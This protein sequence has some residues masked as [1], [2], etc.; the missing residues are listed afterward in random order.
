MPDAPPIDSTDPPAPVEQQPTT[1]AT[2]L[3]SC[4]VSGSVV[5]DVQFVAGNGNTTYHAAAL[6]NVSGS[7]NDDDAAASC[8][9][10]WATFEF[11]P[12]LTEALIRV[13]NTPTPTSDDGDEDSDD[14][15]SNNTTASTTRMVI[16]RTGNSTNE[17]DDDPTTGTELVVTPVG[18]GTV[19]LVVTV[20]DPARLTVSR[21]T[22]TFVVPAIAASVA[23]SG[24]YRARIRLWA[25]RA[26]VVRNVRLL[27]Y[28]DRE[29]SVRPFPVRS[30]SSACV[31]DAT[32]V[33][34][35]CA[36]SELLP[37]LPESTASRRQQ[38]L[39]VSSNATTSD[40][41]WD[42]E[43]FAPSAPGYFTGRIVAWVHVRSS[44][45]PAFHLAVELTPD[46]ATRIALPTPATS[47]AGANRTASGDASGGSLGGGLVLAPPTAAPGP[48]P[49]RGPVGVAPNG[50][51]APTPTT[52][53]PPALGQA[54]VRGIFGYTSS[55]DGT[56]I[57]FLAATLLAFAILL[58]LRLVVTFVLRRR[59]AAEADRHV[60]TNVPAL[61]ALLRVHLYAGAAVPCHHYCGPAHTVQLLAHAL[62]LYAIAAAFVNAYPE[63]ASDAKGTVALGAL[64][65]LVAAIGQPVVAL[66]FTLYR[67]VDT[68]REPLPQSAP[69]APHDLERMTARRP[70][71]VGVGVSTL[72]ALDAVAYD[73]GIDGHLG[74]VQ[75]IEAP[76]GEGTAIDEWAFDPIA[77]YGD[78]GG[79]GARPSS[80]NA[81]AAVDM[82]PYS[83]T[84][85]PK[86]PLSSDSQGPTEEDGD[87]EQTPVAHGI[88]TSS[89]DDHHSV[90]TVIESSTQDTGTA[91]VEPRTC[92]T[93]DVQTC[94]VVDSFTFSA[95]GYAF[96]VFFGIAL[97]MT[98]ASATAAWCAA[99][100]ALFRDV[101]LIAAAADIIGVQ[102]LV[103]GATAAWRWLTSEEDPNDGDSASDEDDETAVSPRRRTTHELHPI[104]GQWRYV[105]AL[106]SAADVAADM[107]EEDTK[108]N[109]ER[110]KSEKKSFTEEN[111]PLTPPPADAPAWS[112]ASVSPSR[113]AATTPT[114]TVLNAACD[115]DDNN[116]GTPGTTAL[117]LQD[118]HV[119]G[120]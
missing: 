119:A 115:D 113:S 92:K 41:P 116:D 117:Q 16:Q 37:R 18:P 5:A 56:K 19:T 108:G 103:M 102:A 60:T 49:G 2:W 93:R 99:E 43:I 13:A 39:A 58:V 105:G 72:T 107:E 120:V 96:A 38:S 28:T 62:S 21:D 112:G 33:S 54:L 66:P 87:A 98:V 106:R 69:Y 55:C 50:T 83:A 65:A 70:K 22:R 101:V 111:L 51:A 8:N 109:D 80:V 36:R 91:P 59:E 17:D 14:T 3:P 6:L 57:N 52:A 74:G 25:A 78:D 75:D 45:A 67:V 1:L 76:H 71:M 7:D 63:L 23:S 73:R 89:S 46:N 95:V 81:K 11:P 9:G 114:T 86:R 4:N 94:V 15:P 40:G 24:R 79:D 42:L 29:L 34:C 20:R 32:N 90:T 77:A 84:L 104:D 97:A 27:A 118:V 31:F 64:T 35:A 82:S 61:P 100:M 44:N 85:V 53:A 10:T 30:T 88:G 26:A 47:N 68:R 12:T 48:A 110:L